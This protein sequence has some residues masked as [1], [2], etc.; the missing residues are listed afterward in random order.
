MEEKLSDE[1]RRVMAVRWQG[2]L[3]KQCGWYPSSVLY[4][5]ML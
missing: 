5:H 3:S 2:L 4:R 1:K